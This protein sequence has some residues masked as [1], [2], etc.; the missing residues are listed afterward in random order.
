MT[1]HISSTQEVPS[2]W[3]QAPH[4]TP[5]SQPASAL[6]VS[7]VQVSGLPQ[8]VFCV[9]PLS[10]SRT[11]LIFIDLSVQYFVPLWGSALIH[12]VDIPDW[13]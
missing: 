2:G 11:P 3:Q 12:C 5:G 4:P 7:R 10:L 8:W 13:W 1:Q 9:W 6:A